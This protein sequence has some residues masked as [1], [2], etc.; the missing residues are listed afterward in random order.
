MSQLLYLFNVKP[1]DMNTST[2]FTILVM[3]LM[4]FTFLY[5]IDRNYIRHN[6]S[7]RN[8]LLKVSFSQMIRV[9]PLGLGDKKI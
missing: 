4:S 1:V 9:N 5:L 7:W 8:W 2:A 3:S 6:I